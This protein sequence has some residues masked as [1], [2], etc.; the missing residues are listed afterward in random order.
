LFAPTNRRAPSVVDSHV[1]EWRGGSKYNRVGIIGK[2]AFATVYL[3]ATKFEGTFYAAKEVE[4]RRFMKNGILDQKVDMEMKIMRKIHHVSYDA[5][6][7][8]CPY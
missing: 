8:W 4:K 3:I 7:S 6:G 2:G 1:K 5:S